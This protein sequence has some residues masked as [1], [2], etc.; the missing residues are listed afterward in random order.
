MYHWDDLD[1]MYIQND[2]QRGSHISALSYMLFMAGQLPHF[3]LT[4]KHFDS[5]IVSHP[6]T[7]SI[8]SKP[9]PYTR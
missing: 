2:P 5:G 7:T 8:D 1:T 3:R 6:G 4:R 9:M